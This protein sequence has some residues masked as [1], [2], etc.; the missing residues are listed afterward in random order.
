MEGT[1]QISVSSRDEKVSA[2]LRAAAEDKIGRL[3]RF[4]DGMDR[5]D[6]HFFEEHNPRIADR[7]VCE[8]T[9]E[10]HGHTVRCKVAAPDAFAAVDR[11]S[12]KLE[13]Q[14]HK[15]KTKLER[16]THGAVRGGERRSGRGSR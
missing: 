2:A 13:H 8:V 14:L 5:A 4:V 1:V 10:G 12:A 16:R 6:I 15:L 11:A 3:S 7:Q 9:M